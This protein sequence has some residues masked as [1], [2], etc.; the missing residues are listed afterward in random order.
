MDRR[1]FLKGLGIGAGVAGAAVI[2]P[3]AVCEKWGPKDPE[4]DDPRP[5]SFWEKDAGPFPSSG[6]VSSDLQVDAA[7]IGSGITGLS[8]AL[9]L[10]KLDPGLKLCV[11]DSF[12][13]GSGSSSRNSGHL[14]GEYH[15]WK[16]IL[17]SQGPEAA[18]EWNGFTRRGL[19]SIM[20][21]I[22]SNNIAC[23]LR[24]E[25]LITVGTEKQGKSLEN[26]FAQMKKAG[27]EGKQ[28][29][30]RSFQEKCRTG[31]YSGGIE[32]S[33]SYLVHPGKL[34]KGL[35]EKVIGAGI[36]VCGNSPVLE[37]KISDSS[38][39]ANLLKTPK[40][41][42]A[43]K[44]VFFATNAYTPRLHGLLS[45]KLVPI[46]VAMVATRP[47][48][49]SERKQA[50]FVSANL[51][52]VQTL[53]RTIGITPDQ[54]VF[55]RGIF[56]YAGFN[57]CV[58]KDAEP[59]YGRL[60]K[61]FRQRLPWI[62]GIQITEKW[63]GPV[64]MTFSSRPIAGALDKRRYICAGYNGVGMVDGFYHAQL[65]AHQMLGVNHPDLKYL[66]DVSQAGWIP[67]E[68]GRSIGAKSF[69]RF[70]L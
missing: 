31:F 14:I 29:T 15:A 33:E 43:A 25:P 20:E 24:Q 11:L 12:R 35:L 63:H 36:P 66:R 47:M 30:G 22:R 10:N 17:S 27:L 50:G 70:A 67:P 13:P 57:S 64:A 62:E 3:A 23:D 37:I 8:A 53:S 38:L 34:I 45:S 21:Y 9:S 32:V 2:A 49:E 55:L 48:T 7:I 42:I 39:E 16:S 51:K 58:W 56:G 60:E 65:V 69:F 40:A 68:P 19:G 59:G 1:K 61:E 52:E 54:R 5:P 41:V 46:I 4:L 6:P 26:L 28:E 44:K 18:R